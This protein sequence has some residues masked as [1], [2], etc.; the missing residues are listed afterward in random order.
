[1][2]TSAETHDDTH[3]R[4]AICGHVDWLRHFKTCIDKGQLEKDSHHISCDDRC[5]FG[6]W[7]KTLPFESNDPI[8]LKHSV[9]VGLHRRFHAAAAEIA[10]KVEAGDRAAASE[11]Y[12]SHAFRRL[13]NSL[14]LN[15]NDWRQDFKKMQAK[16]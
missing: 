2:T 15:L 14:I 8:M 12:T 11:D 13:T 1:M 7:L 9:V 6:K 5:E 3:I 4:D 10:R 16:H